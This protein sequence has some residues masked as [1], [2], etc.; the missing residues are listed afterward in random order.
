MS[1]PELVTTAWLR[2]DQVDDLAPLM[3][4]LARR[5][6]G[7]PLRLQPLTAPGP[8]ALVRPVARARCAVLLPLTMAPCAQTDAAVAE[9]IATARWS[10]RVAPA[11]GSQ[12]PVTQA[13]ADLI[14]RAG[15]AADDA[16]IV[17]APANDTAVD[18]AAR[19]AVDAAA[20]AAA[21]T[22]L[23][24]ATEFAGSTAI[25]VGVERI[26]A[27]VSR[28]RSAGARR[29]VV[30]PHELVDTGFALDCKQAARD[31]GVLT[32]REPLAVQRPVIDALVEQYRRTAARIERA[33]RLSA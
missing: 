22:G 9:L 24:L 29:V 13:I 10:V 21:W 31:A 25:A 8:H 18:I 14:R 27:V 2:H 11:I 19:T 15:L 23:S 6:P 20:R 32:F 3:T 16:V 4:A 17:A 30:V 33:R 12:A 7:V 26:E 28:C 5:L 1:R